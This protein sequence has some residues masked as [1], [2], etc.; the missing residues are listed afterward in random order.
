MSASTDSPLISFLNSI[1]G[2]SN[3]AA[4]SSHDM[5]DLSSILPS[6]SAQLQDTVSG[7]PNVMTPLPLD[8]DL[9]M[10][11]RSLD[12][13]S[14]VPKVSSDDIDKLLGGINVDFSSSGTRPIVSTNVSNIDPLASLGIDLG[15]DLSAP[16][17]LPST[18]LSSTTHEPMF[19]LNPL[20]DLS[21][22]GLHMASMPASPG[23]SGIADNALQRTG[24]L[25]SFGSAH[26]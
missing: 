23:L 9:D 2:G 26:E 16:M 11:M 19:T 14:S 22:A 3:S 20:A 25:S 15:I 4:L 1:S 18:S 24:S 5:L 12:D 21:Q 10:L 13:S 8:A 7:A 17:S 6:S